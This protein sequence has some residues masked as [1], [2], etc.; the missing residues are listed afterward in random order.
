MTQH[1][2]LDYGSILTQAFTD[3]VQEMLSGAAPHLRVTLPNPTTVRVTA[4]TGSDQASLSVEGQYRYRSS[5]VDR[6]HPGGAA[7]VY[8]VFATAT[9]NDF[10][11]PIGAGLNPDLTVHTFDLAIV[12]TGGSPATAIKRK[13]AEIDWDGAAITALRQLTGDRLDTA[14]ITPTAPLAGVTPLVI[15]GVSGQTAAL[16]RLSVA[17]AQ[18]L[19]VSPSG[20]VMFGAA[21]DTTLQRAS[22]GVLS[23]PG[24][25]TIGGALTAAAAA[26]S[27]TLTASTLSASTALAVP[28]GTLGTPGLQFSADLDTGVYRSAPNTLDITA[29]GVQVARLASA[30]VTLSQPV[31]VTGALAAGAL[32]TAGDLNLSSPGSKLV[33]ASDTTLQRTSAGVLSTPGS[34][35]VAGTLTGFTNG[36]GTG[37]IVQA[38]SPTL[39]GTPLAP[40]ATPGTSTTQIATTAFVLANGTTLSNATPIVDGTAAAG[41]ATTA[42]RADHVHPTDTSRAALASPTFTGD[43]K[44]PTPTVGDNDTSIATTAFVSTAISNGTST[45]SQTIGDGTSTTIDVTHNLGTQSLLATVRQSASPYAE[46][47]PRVEFTSNNVTRFIFDIAPTAGQYSVSILGRGTTSP[48]PPSHASSHNPGGSDSLNYAAIA[49]QVGVD[50]LATLIWTGGL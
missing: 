13:I 45:F 17:G 7:G 41:V 39:S 38:A 42:A 18:V 11:G 35:T 40:T 37:S 30:A 48:T 19:Q 21:A 10:S 31:T 23:T 15:A 25:L 32:G 49:T 44:A 33:I 29:G 9:A 26:I 2:A 27:G 47:Y 22:A 3:T 14:P 46:V 16:T 20:A 8:D 34:L 12:T 43:P 24:A 4:A 1:N 6:V 28:D 50:D 5:D 36:T